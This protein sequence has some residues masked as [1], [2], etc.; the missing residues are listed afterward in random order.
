MS[1]NAKSTSQ[2]EPYWTTAEDNHRRAILTAFYTSYAKAL[3]RRLRGAFPQLVRSPEDA[4][5]AVQTT[6]LNMWKTQHFPPGDRENLAAWAWKIGKN[7]VLQWDRAGHAL[8]RTPAADYAYDDFPVDF[9]EESESGDEIPLWAYPDL[10]KGALERLT[11]RQRELVEM[12]LEGRSSYEIQRHMGLLS[13][14]YRVLR[15][16]AMRCLREAILLELERS[17]FASGWSDPRQRVVDGLP[18]APLVA[19]TSWPGGHLH[20]HGWIVPRS[21]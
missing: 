18:S 5:D 17:P 6:F 2:P 4:E 20:G 21:P 3:G 1:S 7:V 8:K 9:V 15:S 14:S 16:N 10:L 13:P 19:A 11:P 12:E